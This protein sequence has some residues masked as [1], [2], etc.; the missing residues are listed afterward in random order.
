MKSLLIIFSEIQAITV[1][2]ESE[3]N[4]TIISAQNGGEYI[5]VAMNDG[6]I[7]ASISTINVLPY[8]TVEPQDTQVDF[9]SSLTLSCSAEGYPSV[10]GLQWQI[11]Q[12]SSNMFVPLSGQ[13]EEQLIF[14]EVD[15][16]VE[17]DYRCIASNSDGTMSSRESTVTGN[18]YN[19]YCIY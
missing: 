16:N 1:G 11:R 2:L 8:F 7:D 6:G 18:N 10:T 4:V 3:I 5:C 13:T 14:I 19:Y 15:S 17:A 12:N 9:G